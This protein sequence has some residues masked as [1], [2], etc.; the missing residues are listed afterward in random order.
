MK[1]LTEEDIIQIAALL[2]HAAKIDEN[3]SEK[4][5]TIVKEFINSTSDNNNN[6]QKLIFEAE[7]LEK[8]SNQLLSFTNA[9]KNNTNETKSFVIEKLWQIII[10]DKNIDHF[11]S[12]LMRRICGLI[13]FSDKLSG[14]IKLKIMNK[15]K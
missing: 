10:Y 6:L 1:K 7:K 12:N 9:I 11:E 4:E 8:D 3:Y 2:I 15:N 13:Y 14:E 5:K